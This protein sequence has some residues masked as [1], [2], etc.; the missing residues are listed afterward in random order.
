MMAVRMLSQVAWASL[1]C[2][3]CL[4][5]EPCSCS[6]LSHSH[7][8]TID[9]FLTVAVLL[10]DT[11]SLFNPWKWQKTPRF[12]AWSGFVTFWCSHT[13]LALIEQTVMREEV[14]RRVGETLPGGP[15]YCSPNSP[16]FSCLCWGR[17]RSTWHVSLVAV[18]KQGAGTGTERRCIALAVLVQKQVRPSW[19]YSHLLLQTAANTNNNSLCVCTWGRAPDCSD[20]YSWGGNHVS[21]WGEWG[22]CLQGRLGIAAL[23]LLMHLEDMEEYSARD[24]PEKHLCWESM[25]NLQYRQHKKCTLI[26]KWLYSICKLL[27]KDKCGIPQSCS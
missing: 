26:C 1:V 5:W 3:C 2:C 20:L 21:C 15:L 16:G 23:A 11:T 22:W 25:L 12:P 19:K 18:S 14:A 24:S 17:A 7:D 13:V 8:F 4:E 9:P 10:F 27:K 6:V